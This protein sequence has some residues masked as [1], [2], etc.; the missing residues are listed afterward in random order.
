MTSGIKGAENGKMATG[1][2]TFKWLQTVTEL[3]AQQTKEDTTPTEKPAR[4]KKTS[5]PGTIVASSS[6]RGY[7]FFLIPAV[8]LT[9][10]KIC[11]SSQIVC[12]ISDGKAIIESIHLKSS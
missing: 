2:N 12:G 11:G 3:T 6:N 7:R 5:N 8:A 10:V 4:G 9:T 1:R